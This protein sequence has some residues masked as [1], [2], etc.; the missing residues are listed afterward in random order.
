[1]TR[2]FPIVTWLKRLDRFGLWTFLLAPIPLAVVLLMWY[3]A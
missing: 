2:T 3:A 1:M